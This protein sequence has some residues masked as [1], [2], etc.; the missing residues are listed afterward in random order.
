MNP[1]LR[2]NLWLELTTHRLVAMPAVLFLLF[3]LFASRDVSNWQR[4]VLSTATALFI[5]VVHLWGTYKA[6]ESVTDEV[7]D[8]TWDWQRLSALDPWRMTWGKLAGATALSWYGA[9]LCAVAMAIALLGGGERPNFLIFLCGLVASGVALH[10]AALAASLQASRKS[11]KL[12]H[13]MGLFFVLPVAAMALIAIASPSQLRVETIDWY[14]HHFESMRF[15][16]AVA[17]VL[18]LWA[19]LAAYREMAVELKLR[20]LP[21]AYPAFAVFVAFF[22]A[23]YGQVPANTGTT[24]AL[25]G[26]LVSL[27]LTYYGL[28]ADVTT[29]MRLR[30]I[31]THWKARQW[32]RVIEELPLWVTTLLVA[33]PFALRSAQIL[34]DVP[35]LSL[36]PKAAAL[37]PVAVLL[38]VVRDCAIYVFFALS[39]RPRGPEG[40]TLLYIALASWILPAVLAVAGLGAAAQLLMPFGSMNGWQASLVMGAQVAIVAALVAWRW[41]RRQRAFLAG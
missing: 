1:E 25:S 26:L 21:W 27:A 41:R 6:A 34:V 33:L 12:G 23:G 16:S 14:G 37:Y 4:L 15:Y 8:R 5:V 9:L 38:L 35:P 13:R 30:R 24:L 20:L 19:V 18:A 22:F 10:G 39:S 32:R 28:F 7:R 3:V 2:R 31:A 11:S 36:V 29:A 17:V 40:V